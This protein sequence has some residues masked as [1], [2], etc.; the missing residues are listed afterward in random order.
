MT[1]NKKETKKEFFLGIMAKYPLTDYEKERFEH[2]I[3]LLDK[4]NST[5][6]K[7]TK[8]QL[9][10]ENLTTAIYDFL[11]DHPETA[12]TVTE[13]NKACP[14]LAKIDASTSK[15]TQLLKPLKVA[16]KIKNFTEKRKSYYQIAD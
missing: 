10:N 2:E 4:K 15:T 3:E 9:E 7:P 13:L 12:Y 14:A 8:N 16:G 5:E 6:R 11:C 1:N